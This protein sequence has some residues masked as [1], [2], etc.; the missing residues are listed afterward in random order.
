MTFLYNIIISPIEIIIDYVFTLFS[1]Q[2]FHLGPLVCLY[3]IS[4]VVNFLSLPVYRYAEKLQK[5]TSAKIKKLENGEKRIK[6]AFKGNER[7]MMPSRVLQTKQLSAFRKA[8]EF[9]GDNY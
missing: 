6:K 8:E 9:N 3:A 1:C 5:D 7:F 4:L 2:F